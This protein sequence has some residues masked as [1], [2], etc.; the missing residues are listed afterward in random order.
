MKNYLFVS[1]SL[2]LMACNP[3]KDKYINADNLPLVW[4]KIKQG[5]SLS[6]S[7]RDFFENLFEINQGRKSYQKYLANLMTGSKPEDL[8]EI[9]LNELDFQ[10]VSNKIF[11]LLESNKVTY[12][13][14]LNEIAKSDSLNEYYSQQ[15]SL[16][17]AEID[18]VCIVLDK[19]KGS[20][21]QYHRPD[22]LYGYC[23]YMDDN[24]PLYKKA[25]TIRNKRDSEIESKCSILSRIRRLES[26]LISG[27]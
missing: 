2:L 6:A 19:E 26:E 5:K 27:L 21:L 4:D 22:V 13:A 14:I 25:E 1:I 11:K 20:E 24:H 23:P 15:L 3:Y 16:V 12:A 9:M 10:Y 8:D 17:Y 18:S 7:Q